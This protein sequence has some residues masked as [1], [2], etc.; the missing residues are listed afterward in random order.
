MKICYVINNLSG[1]GAERLVFRY[2]E[3]LTGLGHSVSVIKLNNCDNRYT[4]NPKSVETIELSEKSKYSIKILVKL[5][6]NLKKENY[7]IVH[8][9]LFPSLYYVGIISHF[10]K[11]IY[12]FHE[13]NTVNSRQKYSILRLVDKWMVRKFKGI[14][15]ISNAVKK[16]VIKNYSVNEEFVR[17]IYNGI[18][19]KEFKIRN[20]TPN[21]IL[22]VCMTARFSPQKDHVTLIKAIACL[23][24]VHL[25]L[26]GDGERL[27]Y[28]KN[29][30]HELGLVDR[31]FFLGFVNNVQKVLEDIDVAVLSSNW[32]GFGLAAVE[33]MA[34][35]I[36]TVV[37]NVEGLN[38][39]VDIEELQFKKGDHLGLVKILKTLHNDKRFYKEMQ[40]RCLQTS[41]KFNILKTSEELSDYYE[42]FICN[43]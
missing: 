12:I 35:S 26:L 7:D 40:K 1:G 25:F 42:G 33:S 43:K 16:T 20:N 34:L 5:Y 9:H 19:L 36:P 18:D 8:V 10:L 21:E 17:R 38:E 27:N 14:I 41:V 32:E 31:I 24:N 37:T 39:V 2:A 6:N 15:A 30:V 22:R 23:P 4:L 28:I 13:H 29:L 3:I 11:N